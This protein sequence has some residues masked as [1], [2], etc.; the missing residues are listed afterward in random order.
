[1]ATITAGVSVSSNASTA[2]VAGPLSFALS[3]A[4]SKA[5]TVNGSVISEIAG[6]TTTH[7]D[8]QIFDEGTQGHA[9]IYV[10]NTSDREI[11]LCSDDAGTVGNRFMSIG[12]SEFAFFPWSGTRDIYAD[13]TGSGTKNLEYFIFLKS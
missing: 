1:M 10:K 7:G 12:P 13:H 3:L 2:T 9:Y 6:V 5:I 11:F 4:A 8:T